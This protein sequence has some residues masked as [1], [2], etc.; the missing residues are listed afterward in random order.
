MEGDREETLDDDSGRL[1][2]R[3]DLEIVGLPLDLLGYRSLS[4]GEQLG[5]LLIRDY[6][7]VG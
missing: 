6:V 5:G 7:G 4:V 2:S 3:C 1:F